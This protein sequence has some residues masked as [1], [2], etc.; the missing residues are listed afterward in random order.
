VR[1]AHSS[2][3]TINWVKIMH[4][5]KSYILQ[6]Q[7]SL[8][9]LSGS[10]NCGCNCLTFA[11]QAF[12]SMLHMYCISWWKA[13]PCWLPACWDSLL[14]AGHSRKQT[15]QSRE[16]ML[17]GNVWCV[18]PSSAVKTLCVCTRLWFLLL[19][20]GESRSPLNITNPAELDIC[21]CILTVDWK[22]KF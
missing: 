14:A 13:E 10:N 16:E 22:L 2:N 7:S 8:H 21:F 17:W 5:N 19:L 3:R 18:C 12:I 20:R 4:F 11:I 15:D 9:L 6:L 1:R